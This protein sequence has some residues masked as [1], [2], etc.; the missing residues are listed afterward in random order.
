MEG[1]LSPTNIACL[2]YD[3]EA[4]VVDNIMPQTD[5]SSVGKEQESDREKVKTP[6]QSAILDM[7]SQGKLKAMASVHVVRDMRNLV[8]NTYNMSFKGTGE[9]AHEKNGSA[10]LF[11]PLMHNLCNNM[12]EGKGKDTDEMKTPW[13]RKS[14]HLFHWTEGEIT[15]H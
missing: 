5:E 15:L 11:Q 2:I 13:Y 9:S 4:N 6:G 7:Q 12:G 14:R 10:P 8:K 1:T 3:L